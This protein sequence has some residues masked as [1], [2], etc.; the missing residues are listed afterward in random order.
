MDG[1]SPHGHRSPLGFAVID[2]ETTGFSPNYHRVIELAVVQTDPVGTV[3]DE[4]V[5]RFNPKRPVGATFVHGITDDDVRNEPP[6]AEFVPTIVDL[7]KGRAL[8]A[9]N[10]RFDLAFLRAEFARAGW[11]L[12]D[13]PVFCTLEASW[14]YL[15]HLDRRRLDDCCR[16]IG[17]EFPSAHAAL[18]DARATAALVATFF[19]PSVPP[20]PDGGDLD[21][22]VAAAS[23]IWPTA[24]VG[25]IHIEEVPRRSGGTGGRRGSVRIRPKPLSPPLLALLRDYPLQEALHEGAPD[26]SAAY[27]ELVVEVLEDGVLS[28]REGH[29]LAGLAQAYGLS[30]DDITRAHRGFL[31]ALGHLAMSDGTVSRGERQEMAGLCRLLGEPEDLISAVISDARGLAARSASEGLPPLPDDWALGE[32]LRVGDGVAF[33]GCDEAQRWRLEGAAKAAGV[34]VTGSVSG[35]TAMLVSDG[36]MDGLKAAAARRHGTRV[37]HPDEFEVLLRHVQPVVVNGSSSGRRSPAAPADVDLV[38]VRIW[39]RAH[40]HE[41]GDRGRI[42]IDIIDAYLAAMQAGSGSPDEEGSR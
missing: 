24:S 39:A 17:H 37:V 34:R 28:V 7:V 4:W 22:P 25:E 11:R 23:V 12:P 15:P 16:A 32:P 38:A 6:F 29:E 30:P 8:V 42:R 5:A 41:V 19:N 31:L 1:Y 20:E 14:H 3:S 13:V 2:V 35:T 10:A 9:H 33:T 18:G 27:L 40:G 26:G 21:L 36:T